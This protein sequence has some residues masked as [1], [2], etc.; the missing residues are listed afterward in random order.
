M[1][2]TK[3][4]SRKVV[5]VW[6]V[7]GLQVGIYDNCT[8]TI[9]LYEDR[10]CIKEPYV[11]WIGNTGGYAEAHYRVT[12]PGTVEDLTALA[13]AE[14]DDSADYTEKAREIADRATEYDR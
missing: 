9:R 13:Q 11:K 2:E 12:D 1:T 4:V 10:V 6:H 14:L 3:A 5:K 7:A 8:Q